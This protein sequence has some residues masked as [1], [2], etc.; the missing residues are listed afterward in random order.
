MTGSAAADESGAVQRPTDIETTVTA[1]ASQDFLLTVIT[2]CLNRADRIAG[3]LDSV[4]RQRADDI[5]HL[6]ID[7]GSKDG[8]LDVVARYPSVRVVS[9]PDKGLYDAMNK[10]I[11]LARGRYILLLNS[12]DELADGILAAARGAMEAGY[13][14]IC[15]GTDFRKFKSDGGVDVL[16]RIVSPELI[17]LSPATSAL[18]SP[19][20]NAKILRRAFLSTVG[21]FNLAYRLAADVD[22]LLR[23]AMA[24]PKVAVLPVVGHHY[25]EHAG[26]LTINA[27]G[28]NFRRAIDECLAIAD[29][30]LARA[31]VTPKVRFLMQAWRGGKRYAIARQGLR[32]GHGMAAAIRLL[33]HL[34]DAVRYGW[35][36]VRRKLRTSEQRLFNEMT[37]CDPSSRCG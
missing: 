3:A 30:T 18:G 35:Y 37:Y 28:N 6:V 16:G 25:F 24:G 27:E 1:R 36:L 15:F 14:A 31:D 4:A 34:P 29:D 26:S 2:V 11:R 12:D 21:E 9:E 7:G 19:L 32:Q 10:G 20:I 22:L 23:A 5:E 8:T 17:I 33:P 13:D